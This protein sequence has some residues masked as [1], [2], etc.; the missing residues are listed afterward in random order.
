M[1]LVYLH[2]VFHLEALSFAVEANRLHRRIKANFIAE[3]EAVGKR[4]LRAVDTCDYAVEFMGF[5]A[6]CIGITGKPIGLDR[7]VVQAGFLR[8]SRQRATWISWGI[9]VVI[10]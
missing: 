2:G 10:S 7:W 6:L 1:I 3:L 9:W 5:H 4:L 8:T